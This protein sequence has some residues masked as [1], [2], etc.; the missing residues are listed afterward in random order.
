M[1]I[2]SD[3][4]ARDSKIFPAA[5]NSAVTRQHSFCTVQQLCLCCFIYSPLQT[6]LPNFMQN[7][8]KTEEVVR[9]A[10]LASDRPTDWHADSY[11]PY[12]LRECGGIMTSWA[13][14]KREFNNPRICSLCCQTAKI[15]PAKLTA[16][17]Y[18]VIRNVTECNC[19][20]CNSM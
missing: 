16:F 9:D 8:S 15:Y 14:A 10:R 1:T 11:M 4:V 17:Q 7:W 3:E 6:S 5:H 18:T 12:T 13:S 2:T 20:E 19:H